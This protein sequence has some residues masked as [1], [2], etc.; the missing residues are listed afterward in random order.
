MIELGD[1]THTTGVM[2]MPYT[3]LSKA[4]KRGVLF[5]TGWMFLIPRVLGLADARHERWDC[6]E[7]LLHEAMETATRVGS[8]PELA[9]SYLDYADM[10]L[11]RDRLNPNPEAIEYAEKALVIFHELEM[12]PFVKRTT[13]LMEELQTHQITPLSMTSEYRDVLSPHTIE[14]LQ[15]T[16]KEHTTFLG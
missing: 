12:H 1:A 10:L 6:A 9:R 7:A 8:R 5:S 15:Y 3:M 16:T 2:D 4:F 11:A 13:R 14:L